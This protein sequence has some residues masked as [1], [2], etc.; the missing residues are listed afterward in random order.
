[1]VLTH[2]RQG[3]GDAA[4]DLSKGPGKFR[5]GIAA[6]G[7]SALGQPVLRGRLSFS[8]G[9]AS[10]VFPIGDVIGGKEAVAFQE[11]PLLKPLQGIRQ[12]G[13]TERG[14]VTDA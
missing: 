7:K 13:I 12:E 3:R 4:N 14:R 2:L 8:Q 9:D 5:C 6:T 1:V 10:P 11:N